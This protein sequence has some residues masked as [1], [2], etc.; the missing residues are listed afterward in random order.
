MVGAGGG[1]SCG[2]SPGRRK[3]KYAV[4]ESGES[5]AGHGAPVG[6]AASVAPD[7]SSGSSLLIT[8]LPPQCTGYG[9]PSPGV[10]TKGPLPC[11]STPVRE[12]WAGQCHVQ[13]GGASVTWDRGACSLSSPNSTLLAAGHTVLLARGPSAGCAT[14]LLPVGVGT[15]SPPGFFLSLRHRASTVARHWPLPSD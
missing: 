14:P 2:V 6:K 7:P 11:P 5:R 1:H 8:G 3:P 4:E 13:G 10:L 12:P 15:F 9:G